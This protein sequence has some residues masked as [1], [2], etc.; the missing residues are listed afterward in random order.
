M[1][2]R[3]NLSE[4]LLAEDNGLYIKHVYIHAVFF[5]LFPFFFGFCLFPFS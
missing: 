3:F 2:I 4:V 1:N 5:F